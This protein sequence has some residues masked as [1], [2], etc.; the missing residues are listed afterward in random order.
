MNLSSDFVN[1]LFRIEYA[2]VTAVPGVTQKASPSTKAEF[3]EMINGTGVDE[4][5]LQRER[6]KTNRWERNEIKQSPKIVSF[7]QAPPVS[8]DAEAVFKGGRNDRHDSSSSK[9]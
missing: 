5:E 9:V 6:E 3:D 8:R 2:D 4:A 7:F 1:L